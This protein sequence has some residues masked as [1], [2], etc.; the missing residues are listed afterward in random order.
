M[1]DFKKG[2]YVILLSYPYKDCFWENSMPL[3][4]CYILSKD[5]TQFDFSF[6]KD[7]NDCTWNGWSTINRDNQNIYLKFR[8]ANSLEIDEYNKYGKPCKA[9]EIFEFKKESYKYLIKLFKQ[10]NIK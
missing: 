1:T 4:Y 10:L 5:S 3:N 2:D 8:L 7:I 6:E 9:I